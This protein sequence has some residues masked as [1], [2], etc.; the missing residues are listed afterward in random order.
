VNFLFDENIRAI[1]IVYIMATETINGKVVKVTVHL[2][3]TS[4]KVLYDNVKANDSSRSDLKSLSQSLLNMQ[5]KL[6]TFLTGI[7]EQGRES[8]PDVNNGID[9]KN[10]NS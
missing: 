5:A 8:T 3:D 6:N 7:V 10:A 1:P 2:R 4:A 9:G